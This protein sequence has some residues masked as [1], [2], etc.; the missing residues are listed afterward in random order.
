[1]RTS[2]CIKSI[3][4]IALLGAFGV[5]RASCIVGSNSL[6]TVVTRLFISQS[7]TLST[8]Q[9]DNLKRKEL[10]LSSALAHSR[11]TPNL[12][13]DLELVRPM[14]PER[15]IDPGPLHPIEPTP[16][17]PDEPIT[18]EPVHRKEAVGTPSGNLTVS[19]MGAAVYNLKIDVPNG[20]SLTPQLSISYNSQTGGY[21]IAGYGFNL[22]GISVITR[23]GKDLFH[24]GQVKGTAY[25]SSDTYFLDGRRLILQ[26]GN[27]GQNGEIYTV[28]GDPF[29]KV[30]VHGNY[31]N[32]SA[33]TWFEVKASDGTVYQYGNSSNSKLSYRNKKGYA[34]IA[35]WYINRTTDKYSN[36][37]TYDYAIGNFFIRPVGI[38]YGTNSAKNR[39]IVNKVNFFYQNLGNNARPFAVE[40][41]QGLI[42]MCLSS[43]TT[44]S[45][46]SI[47][48]TYTF[49]Y[50]NNSDQSTGKWMRLVTV[51]EANGKG[52]K[53]PPVKFTWQYLPSSSIYSSQLAVSTKDGSS[54]V[55]ETDKQFLSADL[56]GDG[57]SDIIRVSP[58]K[59]TTAVWAGG[60][61]WN[62]YTYVYPQIRNL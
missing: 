57:I 8:L 54:F 19:N 37:I 7:D 30:I 50:N 15:P 2:F 49:S 4:I 36:Y 10:G 52:D 28:E 61:S 34:R 5:T 1:M 39:G 48:R 16:I 56:N 11:P 53:Y 24:D 23:G 13:I 21:G 29:T 31:S 27:A 46:N 45:N 25:T 60:S 22:T 59:V 6:A 58:V 26:S 47:Y 12:P 55:E 33:D 42:D 41:Q 38:T 32:S 3:I 51:E 17:W 14:D 40:D 20:G 62:H 35:S 18:D 9:E 43:I 44:T